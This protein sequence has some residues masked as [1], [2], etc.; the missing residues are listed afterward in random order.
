MNKDLFIVAA[1]AAKRN[2]RSLERELFLDFLFAESREEAEI[3]AKILFLGNTL[4]S[5]EWLNP[6]FEVG[7]IPEPHIRHYRQEFER[8]RNGVRWLIFL[9]GY[10]AFFP[11]RGGLRLGTIIAPSRQ[12]AVRETVTRLAQRGHEY[13]DHIDFSIQ[14]VPTKV[15]L[16]RPPDPEDAADMFRRR[17]EA[18][19]KKNPRR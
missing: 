6:T 16:P 4:K 8:E 15:I 19:W 17:L 13:R 18:Y 10:A 1:T 11:D 7:C 14:K 3:A 9:W 5:E 2:G 12:D